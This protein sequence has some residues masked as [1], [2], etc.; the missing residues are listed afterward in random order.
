MVKFSS[1][2]QAD[3]KQLVWVIKNRLST[4]GEI[5]W[6]FR[7]LVMKFDYNGKQVVLTGT[8][9]TNLQWMQGKKAHKEPESKHQ[10]KLNCTL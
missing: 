2:E 9:N 10:N 8:Q 4:L 7:T 1:I 5:R 6:N 3:E